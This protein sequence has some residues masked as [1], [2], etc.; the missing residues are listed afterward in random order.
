MTIKQANEAKENW[1]AKMNSQDHLDSTFE[2]LNPE[3]NLA[4]KEQ[5]FSFGRKASNFDGFLKNLAH[6]AD[7]SEYYKRV[8]VAEISPHQYTVQF[9]RKPTFD[10]FF[11]SKGFNLGV[12]CPSTQL[13]FSST[14]LNIFAKLGSQNWIHKNSLLSQFALNFPI[15]PFSRT[16]DFSWS[17]FLTDAFDFWSWQKQNRIIGSEIIRNENS[18]SFYQKSTENLNPKKYVLRFKSN[19]FLLPILKLDFK[20][21]VQ[22]SQ[23]VNYSFFGLLKKGH[24]F[25]PKLPFA[26]VGSLAVG[27]S[28]TKSFN[29][30]ENEHLNIF[31][32]LNE[33]SNKFVNGVCSVGHISSVQGCNY[34][35]SAFASL[36]AFSRENK[37]NWSL[38]YGI[39]NRIWLNRRFSLSCFL[40]LTNDQNQKKIVLKFQHNDH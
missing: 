13:P 16:S 3:I 12:F 39:G 19:G 36:S 34:Y 23:D 29:L 31:E 5:L 4:N 26:G 35:M 40:N 7:N 6:F 28:S 32:D 18:I 1:K 17:F 37:T 8:D 27:I 38:S 20:F 9:M 14:S 11:N 30:S 15:F 25:Y 21:S 24:L 2:I 22:N 10:Y 33:K